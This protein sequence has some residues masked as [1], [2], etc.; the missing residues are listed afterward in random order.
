MGTRVSQSSVT[1]KLKA[2]GFNARATDGIVQ[3]SPALTGFA[4]PILAKRLEI[5]GALRGVHFLNGK[6]FLRA[7]EN[8]LH[9]SSLHRGHARKSK[10]KPFLLASLAI[11]VLVLAATTPLGSRDDQSPLVLKQAV[12]NPCEEAL[13]RNWLTTGSEDGDI[14]TIETSILGGVI[15]GTFECL[16]TRYS[17]TLGSE[18]PKR[19]LKLQKLDS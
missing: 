2:K 8:G 11:P 15:T 1:T 5:Q 14:K 12:T 18:E 3:I 10:F 6:V 17:Y 16:D 19:V 13:L 9:L 7:E 4:W